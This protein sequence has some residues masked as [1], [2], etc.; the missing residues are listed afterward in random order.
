MTL[1]IPIERVPEV[2]HRVEDIVLFTRYVG[3]FNIP[4]HGFQHSYL[5]GGNTSLNN[6]ADLIVK[7]SGHFFSTINETGFG[8]ATIDEILDGLLLL[9]PECDALRRLDYVQ[10]FDPVNELDRK[11]AAL[12]TR[13]NRS[14]GELSVEAGFHARLRGTLDGPRINMHDHHS[15]MNGLLNAWEAEQHSARLFSDLPYVKFMEFMET[16]APLAIEFNRRMRRWAA[17][18]GEPTVILMAQHGAIQ[19]G[20]TTR[21][22]LGLSNLVVTRI[23]EDIKSR[24]PEFAFGVETYKLPDAAII[25]QAT[26]YLK[27]VMEKKFAAC[28]GI[29]EDAH[30]MRMLNSDKAL[31][32]I[33]SGSPN[34]DACVYGGAYTMNVDYKPGDSFEKL[35]ANIDEAWKAYQRKHTEES[36][37]YVDRRVYKP[38]IVLIKGLGAITLGDTEKEAL[39]G[40]YALLDTVHVMKTAQAYGG[41][42]PLTY[43]Q[44]FYMTNWALEIRRAR[45]A[46]R[47]R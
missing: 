28:H 7:L 40:H 30:V 23:Q 19:T 39:N 14:G 26:A 34:P 43:A 44:L 5:G 1:A 29:N 13:T 18:G 42:K 32:I 10:N 47:Q 24:L 33:A 11:V 3:Q 9:E 16:G 21:E 37:L 22:V 15:T 25:E 38:K 12:Y 4:E 17:E 2:L 8:I 45:F 6:G 27:N 31:E 35:R 36:P 41:M 20:Y 46:A